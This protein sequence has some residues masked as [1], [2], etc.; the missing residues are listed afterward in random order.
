MKALVLVTLGGGI[1][2]AC[3]YLV[4]ALLMRGVV[5][6]FPLATLVVNLSGCLLIGVWAGLADR[7]RW[8]EG[9]LHLWLVTGVLGGFTTF[10]AFGLESLHLMRRG[11]IVL[12]GIYVGG[13]VLPGLS[14]VMLGWWLAGS[15]GR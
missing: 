13:S 11:E 15:A 8:L 10:S 2:A 1:G 12:A 4:S 9:D 3:R 6:G 5:N 7:Y 14:L